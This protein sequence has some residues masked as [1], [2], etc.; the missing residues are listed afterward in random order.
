[1]LRDLQRV[2]HEE[3]QRLP[4]KYRVPLVLCYLEGRSQEEAARHLVW[5]KSTVRGRLDRGR[6][7]L[8][9]RLARRG[10]ALSAVWC[11]ADLA[12]RTPAIKAAL[13]N[14]VVRAALSSSGDQATSGVVSAK[15]SA[16]AEGV[17]RA[18]F[19]TKAKIA[20][21]VLIAVS[22]LVVAGGAL[23]YQ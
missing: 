22:L 1:T 11:A 12:L 5:A 9:R 21:A 8:R 2:L 19:Q 6:E 14:S 10:M 13:M 20:T 4:D 18:M 17:T 23:A 3:L 15:A 16:L 7:H